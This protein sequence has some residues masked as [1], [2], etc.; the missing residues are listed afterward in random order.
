MNSLKEINE[1]YGKKKKKLGEWYEKRNCYW[2][3]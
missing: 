2:I 3:N 1:K